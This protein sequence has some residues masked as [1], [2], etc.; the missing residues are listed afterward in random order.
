MKYKIN[1]I[2][3]A[4]QDVVEHGEFLVCQEGD[5]MV[6]VNDYPKE[7]YPVYGKDSYGVQHVNTDDFF[8]INESEVC[9]E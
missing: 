1:D 7:K 8:R 9:C 2:V 5:R 3:I 6:I 4:K